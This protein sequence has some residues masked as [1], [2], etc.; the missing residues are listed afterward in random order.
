[1]KLTFTRASVLL[2]LA[3]GLTACGGKASF[4]VTGPVTGLLY[5]GL[6]ITNVINGDTVTVAKPAAAA[7]GATTFTLAKSLDYGQSY[8][9]RVTTE[10]DHESCTLYSG[11]DTAGRLATINITVACAVDEFAIGGTVSGLQAI[12]GSTPSGLVV[13]NGTDR[14]ALEVNGT[15]VMPAKVGYDQSYNVVI[16]SQPTGKTCTIAHPSDI[17]KSIQHTLTVELPVNN[18]DITCVANP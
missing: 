10:P 4:Q 6:V 18:I 16:I 17:V 8:D 14:L 7:N 12:A 13:A 9:V 5:D 2:A 3:I 15:Y 1:M 11:K